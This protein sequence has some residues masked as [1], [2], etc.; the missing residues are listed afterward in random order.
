[1]I[2]SL[3]GLSS[4][5]CPCCGEMIS[6]DQGM[7]RK[8]RISILTALRSSDPDSGNTLKDWT[9]VYE[10][11]QKQALGTRLAVPLLFGI[12]AVHGNNNVLGAVVF[13][14]NIGLGCTRDLGLKGLPTFKP[15]AL[16]D[17]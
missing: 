7:A 12:D 3:F 2:W 8:P 4:N 1:M 15:N 11:T 5:K 6:L 9:G 10:E 13:P 14:H 17:S 16:R